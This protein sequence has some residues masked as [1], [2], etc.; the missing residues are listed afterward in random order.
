MQAMQR[1]CAPR[2][3]RS[4]VLLLHPPGCIMEPRTSACRSYSLG[5]AI[6][7]PRSGPKRS[8]RASQATA[9]ATVFP[10]QPGFQTSRACQLGFHRAQNENAL[11]LC[12]TD[13][14]SSEDA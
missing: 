7:L 8:P 4:R 3:A 9:H 12:F 14:C 6:A 10:G 11:C 1:S 2:R 13:P 5:T